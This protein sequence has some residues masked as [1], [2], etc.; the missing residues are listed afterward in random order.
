M[1]GQLS[2][3]DVEDDAR[4]VIDVEGLLLGGGALVRR[5]EA[6]RISVVVDGGWRAEAL[7]EALAT[8]GVGAEIGTPVEGRCSVRSAFTPR[9]L[10]V[11][12]RWTA[13]ARIRVPDG[14]A[15]RPAALRLWAVAGGYVD[16][17]GYQLRLGATDEQLWVRAGAALAAAGVPGAFLG[18]RAGG[19]AY[20]VVGVRRLT[21]LRTMVGRPPV[22]CDDGHW[23]A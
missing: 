15:L 1:S 16:H 12:R 3:F 6:A 11:A 5:A 9:L 17:S 20:R 23:P 21:R 18:V 2:L 22:D 8:R 4:A 13:G 19:P 10:D 14:F 7:R